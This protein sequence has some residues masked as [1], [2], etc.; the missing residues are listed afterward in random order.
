M[1]TRPTLTLGGLARRV[2]RHLDELASDTSALSTLAADLAPH[3]AHTTLA[4][5]S[6][7]A[8]LRALHDWDAAA[9]AHVGRY[10]LTILPSWPRWRSDPPRSPVQLAALLVTVEVDPL[11]LDALADECR[12]W[13]REYDLQEGSDR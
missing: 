13:G 6:R 4:A 9:I 5:E 7:K 3:S 11:A 2:G 10:P 8:T 12:R 1:T